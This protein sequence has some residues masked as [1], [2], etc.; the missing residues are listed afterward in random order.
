MHGNSKLK[1]KPDRPN[2]YLVGFMGTGKSTLGRTLAK[3]LNMRFIDS[4]TWIEKAEGMKISRIFETHGE[5]YFREKEAEFVR[6]GH[7]ESNCVVACGGGLIVPEEHCR[8][9]ESKGVVIALFATPETILKRTSSNPNRPLLQS[10]DPEETIRKLLAE[11]EQAYRRVKVGLMTDSRSLS[12]LKARILEVYQ[13][14][15]G[16]L[17]ES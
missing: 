8:I 15:L 6:G 14:H 17:S 5:A 2:L 9:L 4:D 13:R 1:T 11:R 3:A 16:E 12:D 7:P 10:A